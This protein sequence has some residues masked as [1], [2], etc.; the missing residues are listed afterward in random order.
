MSSFDPVIFPSF[1]I[2]S[3]LYVSFSGSGKVLSHEAFDFLSYND[4]RSFSLSEYPV[5]VLLLDSPTK[6]W[7][8]PRTQ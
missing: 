4:L 8:D 3:N 5:V 6:V 7:E 2:P 1:T